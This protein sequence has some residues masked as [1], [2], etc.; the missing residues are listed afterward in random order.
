MSNRK[1]KTKDINNKDVRHLY[2]KAHVV[3]KRKNFTIRYLHFQHICCRLMIFRTIAIY[4]CILADHVMLPLLT[5]LSS[6]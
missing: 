1:K 4:Y 2:E 6:S 3:L 5:T